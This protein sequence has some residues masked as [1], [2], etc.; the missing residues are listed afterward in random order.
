MKTISLGFEESPL[1]KFPSYYSMIKRGRGSYGPRFW[2]EPKYQTLRRSE[3]SLTWNLPATSIQTKTER[4]FF[5]KDGTRQKSNQKDAN[6]TRW[7]DMMTKRYA[8]LSEVVPVFAEAK[9]CMDI[10]LVAGLLF[11][12][13]LPNKANCDLSVLTSEETLAL[14]VGATP[15][16]VAADSLC[17]TLNDRGDLVTVTGGIAINPFETIQ[18]N[19]EVDSTL[20]TASQTIVFAG[21]RWIAD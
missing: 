12:E 5:A 7:A 2:I 21:N 20:E 19:V 8:E 15:E 9:N 18:K 1:A 17:R 10:A 6:A 14:P 3:D 13:N 11:M 4:E 16:K